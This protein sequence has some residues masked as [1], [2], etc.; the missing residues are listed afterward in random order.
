MVAV[1]F[2]KKNILI[3]VCGGIAVYK[4]CDLIN[5]LK[6]KGANVEVIMTGNATKF[7]T[8]LTFQ[9]LSGNRVYVDMFEL[10]SKETLEIDHISLAEKCDLLVIAPATANIIGKIASGIADDLLTTVVLSTKAPILIA[11]A[12]NTNMW[13]NKI[14]MNNVKKLKSLGFKFIGPSYGMLACGK[15]G[16]GRL[17]EIDKIMAEIKKILKG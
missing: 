9:T 17:E 14:V 3:G 16:L 13:A 2:S 5:K 8:P 12:M 6:Y 7:V 1:P 4:I 15:K 11:P 10:I